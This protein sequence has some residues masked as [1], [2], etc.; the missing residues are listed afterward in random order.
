MQRQQRS[1]RADHR[2]DMSENGA[3]RHD[4]DLP[5][6]QGGAGRIGHAD[7]FVVAFGAPQNVAVIRQ[8]ERMHFQ[9]ARGRRELC[10]RS[11]RRQRWSSE[12]TIALAAGR[13]RRRAAKCPAHPAHVH[14]LT[15]RRF[16]YK[17]GHGAVRNDQSARI[18]TAS[19][20][21]TSRLHCPYRYTLLASIKRQRSAEP[22]PHRTSVRNSPIRA[23][24]PAWP[25]S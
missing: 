17:P 15:P 21:C 8:I 23:G 22:K 10:R 18:N 7:H 19:F 16:L 2:A 13:V 1:V 14:S 4:R 11:K 24:A 3:V 5:P 6:E 25:A 20:K 12:T 9:T